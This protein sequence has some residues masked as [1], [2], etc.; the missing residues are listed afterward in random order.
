MIA[1]VKQILF[2]PAKYSKDGDLLHPRYAAININVPLE[3]KDE[4]GIR[5][6]LLDALNAIFVDVS[7]VSN[8]APT[9][10]PVDP[11]QQT[12]PIGN[13]DKVKMAKEEVSTIL[14]NLEEDN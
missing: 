7:F 13:D 4:Q 11:R 6:E 5:D 10:K 1:E 12:L 2:K 9:K 14:E 3:G 8:A